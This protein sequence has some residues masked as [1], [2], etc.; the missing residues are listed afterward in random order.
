M[1]RF[2]PCRR[3]CRSNNSRKG[4]PATSA[5]GLGVLPITLRSRSPA[6]PHNTMASG[7]S[8]IDVVPFGDQRLIVTFLGFVYRNVAAFVGKREGNAQQVLETLSQRA[9]AFGRYKEQ[10]E[11]AAA[12]AQQLAAGSPGAAAGL[13]DLI[14]IGIRDFPGEG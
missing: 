7:D 10:H 4:R 11:S 13:V 1:T 8:G 2:D 6:P 3:N 5:R 9:A 12:R 14:D